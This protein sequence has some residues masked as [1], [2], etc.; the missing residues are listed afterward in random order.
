MSRR[1]PLS[2][3][4]RELQLA[5]AEWSE[6]LAQQRFAAALAMFASADDPYAEQWTPQL[7]ETTIRNYGSVEPDPEGR[8]FAITSLH[9]LP[10]LPFDEF[11]RSHI[12][13]DRENLYGLDP[14]HYLGMIHY[15]WVPLNGQPSDLTAR[16][17]IKRIGNELTL[18][19]LDIHVM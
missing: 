10:D 11:V 15:E 7:L 19:F 18:E 13:V 14:A 1:W 9:A 16:F 12:E 2:V 17:Q 5:V 8:T 6:L 3:S 4:D